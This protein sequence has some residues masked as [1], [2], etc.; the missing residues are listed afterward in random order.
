MRAPEI[1][2]MSMTESDF[3]RILPFA[4]NDRAFNICQDGVE[5]C[6][7]AEIIRISLIPQPPRTIAALSLPALKVS[8]NF[9]IL[10]DNAAEGFI[11]QFDRAFHRG[12]G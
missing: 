1:R 11:R 8:I 9:G 7:D 4:L 3:F 10:S 2:L 6:V 5:I 12:G